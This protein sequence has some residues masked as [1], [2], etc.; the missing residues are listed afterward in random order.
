MEGLLLHL[1]GAAALLHRKGE[2]PLR[3]DMRLVLTQ[4][5]N[6]QK[7]HTGTKGSNGPV[8][9]KGRALSNAE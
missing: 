8:A 1:K 3:L 5:N 2:S 9:P 6:R 7:A 4:L